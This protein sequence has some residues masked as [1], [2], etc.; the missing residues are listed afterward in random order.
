MNNEKM[1]Y[2]ISQLRK[3]KKLT[4]KELA[5]QLGVTDKAVSKWERG[6]SFPDISLL[7][8]LANLL[9]VTVNDLV[10]NEKEQSTSPAEG[11]IPKTDVPIRESHKDPSKNKIK[12]AGLSII[13]ITCI[14]LFLSISAIGLGLSWVLIPITVIAALWLISIIGT[15]IMNKHKI[16]SGLL[17]GAVIFA[18]TYYYA[19]LNQ[20]TIRDIARYGEFNGFQRAYIPHYTIIITLF[21]ASLIISLLSSGVIKKAISGDTMFLLGAGSITIIIIAVITVSSIMDYVD[22]HGLS[23]NPKFTILLL[24][25]CLINCLSLA[26]LIKRQL[27]MN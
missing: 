27:N 23:V 4:Q 20:T 14:I 25:S 26:I 9:G 6:L 3:E 24:L 13:P 12:I 2:I 7:P 5:D 18:A 22:I 11:A 15:F 8:K 17:C 1:A 19:S 10:N 16:A 21:V